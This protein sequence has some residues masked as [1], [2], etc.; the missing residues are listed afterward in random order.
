MREGGEKDVYVEN[1]VDI[2]VADNEKNINV[3]FEEVI[4]INMKENNRNT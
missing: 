2:C 4:D 1:R 3:D